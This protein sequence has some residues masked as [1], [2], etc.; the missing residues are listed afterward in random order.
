LRHAFAFLL[1]PLLLTA[2]AAGAPKADS[3][4][5]GEPAPAFELKDQRGK[6]WSLKD[7]QSKPMLI[8]LWATWCAPCIQALPDLERFSK[9][10]GDKVQVLGLAMDIQG[11]PVV[12]PVLRRLEVSY[13][14]ACGNPD[15]S[16][17]YGVTAYPYLVVVQHGAILKRLQGRQNY[18]DL[19]RELQGWLN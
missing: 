10:H 4:S 9:A 15:L 17:A 3:A 19:E 12:T 14:V 13:P 7:S 16:K 6:T 2:C 1:C 5:G 11:W 8:D 18:A